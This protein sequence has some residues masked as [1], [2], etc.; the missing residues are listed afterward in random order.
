MK[1]EG[2]FKL[3]YLGYNVW[4][5]PKVYKIRPQVEYNNKIRQNK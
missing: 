2:N 4:G 5:S 3:S 1:L